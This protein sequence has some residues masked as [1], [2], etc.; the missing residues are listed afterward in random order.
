VDFGAADHRIGNSIP[1]ETGPPQGVTAG[2]WK[3]EHEGE[4]KQGSQP[5]L[6]SFKEGFDK[7]DF[8]HV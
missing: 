3:G 8:A 5:H 7:V 1:T 4:C 2:S 6:T